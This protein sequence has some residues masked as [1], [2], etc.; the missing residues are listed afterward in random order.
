MAC[1]LLL[2]QASV[3]ASVPGIQGMSKGRA[4]IREVFRGSKH[5][6]TFSRYWDD[7]YKATEGG[8]TLH[9]GRP[10]YP[11]EPGIIF[12]SAW[13]CTREARYRQS[14]VSQF[15]FAHSIEND[16]GLLVTDNGFCRDT[17]A[18]QIYNFYTAFKL[19]RDRRYLAWADRCARG[20][21]DHLP[22][23]PRLILGRSFTT[24]VAGFCPA[25]KPYDSARLRPWVDVNQNAEVALAFTLLY[26][27]PR[28]ALYRAPTVRDLCRNEME[29][30]L[31]IQD[32]ATGAVP[33]A[34]SSDRIR[35]FDTAYGSY[36]LFSWVWLNSYWKDPAWE[37]RIEGAARWIAR[38]G[39]A[40]GRTAER[41]YPSVC[42]RL[43]S[44]DLWYR[45]PALWTI[46]SQPSDTIDR[47]V[48][49]VAPRDSVGDRAFLVF[50]Y[51]ELMR[52]CPEFY[53]AQKSR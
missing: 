34:E 14:A 23:C 2:A 17:Q 20:M 25:N 10:E 3:R 41:F 16:D 7:Y 33:L 9:T 19:L 22:R 11:T 13:L 30:G 29:A 27:E 5:C 45:V 44:W 26:H 6:E 35:Q 39:G 47:Y 15:D 31:A 37:R 49:T 48:S 18:R 51:F 42:D 38:Y 1:L 21:L 8:K 36:V 12:L 53:L 50:A 40:D 4:S 28:S 52:I 46:G 43:S 24:F 32:A